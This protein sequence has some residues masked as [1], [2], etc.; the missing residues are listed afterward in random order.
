VDLLVH[1]CNFRDELREHALKTGHSHTT[2]VAEVARTADVGR[3]LLVHINPLTPEEDP[4]GLKEARRI[5]PRIEIGRD[6]MEVE[7]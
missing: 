3:L 5:F 1:E 7:F 2:P 6:Q 4:V